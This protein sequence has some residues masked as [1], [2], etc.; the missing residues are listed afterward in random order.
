MSIK[1]N[2]QVIKHVHE[3]PF[4]GQVL[5]DIMLIC[6]P[7]LEGMLGCLIGIIL[8]GCGMFRENSNPTHVSG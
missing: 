5:K 4:T 1:S 7:S 6:K 8:I 2:H 3:T